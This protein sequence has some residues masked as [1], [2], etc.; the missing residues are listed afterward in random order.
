VFLLYI[1]SA[2]ICIFKLIENISAPQLNGYHKFLVDDEF[3]SSMERKLT[4]NF[5]ERERKEW[6]DQRYRNK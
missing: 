5:E 3:V 2:F 1:H 4:E 6:K